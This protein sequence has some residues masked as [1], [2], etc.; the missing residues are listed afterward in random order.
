MHDI[1]F[2][3]FIQEVPLTNSNKIL[4]SAL[5]QV[6]KNLTHTENIVNSANLSFSINFNFSKIFDLF[7]ILVSAFDIPKSKYNDLYD[8]LHENTL[9]LDNLVSFLDI[10]SELNL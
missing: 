9:S 4:L 7:S 2:Q 3:D 5:L 1:C 10:S 8:L 6:E